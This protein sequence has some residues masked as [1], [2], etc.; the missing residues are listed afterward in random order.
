MR[1]TD[2]MKRLLLAAFVVVCHLG[3]AA[4]YAYCYYFSILIMDGLGTPEWLFFAWVGGI[5]A[6]LFAFSSFWW[7]ALTFLRK[8]SLK[9]ALLSCCL[10]VVLPLAQWLVLFM[11]T[12]FVT[13]ETSAV[14][15]YIVALA[16]TLPGVLLGLGSYLLSAHVSAPTLSRQLY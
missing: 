5:V 1:Y 6:A 3:L 8:S 12:W 16:F 11:S 7:L 4:V 13:T 10:P 2:R 15:Y 9:P 14:G